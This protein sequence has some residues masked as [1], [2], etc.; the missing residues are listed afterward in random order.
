MKRIALV[1]VVAC[2]SNPSNDGDGGLDAAPQND[3]ASDAIAQTDVT[4]PQGS[5]A[6]KYPGDVGMQSDP[7]VVW[8]E[9]F[10][11]GSATAV[12]ARYDSHANPPGLT[13][14]T[15]VPGKSSGKS[16]GRMTS[17]G[18]TANATDLYKRLSRATTSGTCAGTRSMNP[19]RSI[20]TTR[21]RGSADT[22]RAT[23]YPEP[24]KRA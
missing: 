12:G 18:D 9:N 10:E 13:L 20:G 22:T 11:E 14:E 15:D 3:A 24:D 1:F 7:A 6:T 17:N 4:P 19:A 8:M 21:A 16:S 5:L 23:T 2:S